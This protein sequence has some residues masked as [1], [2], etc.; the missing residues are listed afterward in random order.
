M[1]QESDVCETTLKP[2][3]LDIFSTWEKEENMTTVAPC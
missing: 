1:A 3:S 2:L